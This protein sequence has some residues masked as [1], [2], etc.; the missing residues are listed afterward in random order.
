MYINVIVCVGIRQ[1]VLQRMW[2][3]NYT[4]FWG[5]GLN[6]GELITTVS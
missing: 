2:A 3:M 1:V 5:G 4:L 6:I